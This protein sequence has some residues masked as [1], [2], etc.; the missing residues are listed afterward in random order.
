MTPG[1]VTGFSGPA[2]SLPIYY[3]PPRGLELLVEGGVA[4]TLSQPPGQVFTYG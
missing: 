3:P 4:G 2:T 1:D